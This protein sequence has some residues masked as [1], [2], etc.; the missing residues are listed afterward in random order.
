MSLINDAL[1]RASTNPKPVA[2]AAVTAEAPM[3]PVAAAAASPA[4]PH[5][6]A[7][8]GL[9][10]AMVAMAAVAGWFFLKWREASGRQPAVQAAT[11]VPAA[12]SAR[13]PEAQAAKVQA[14]PATVVAAAAA[15]TPPAIKP[16]AQASTVA[17]RP[18]S[19]AKT[20]PAPKPTPEPIVATIPAAVPAPATIQPPVMPDLKLQA[21]VF[22]MKNPSALINGRHVKVGDEVSGVRVVEIQRTTVFVEWQGKKQTLLMK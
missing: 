17:T 22:R 9:I 18:E 5:S 15:S 7:P 19:P 14:Q 2:S 20:A 13:L 12:A 8:I 6:A 11:S 1:K 16:V 21:I 4:K 10:V 3:V